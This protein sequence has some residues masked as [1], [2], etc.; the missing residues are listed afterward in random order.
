MEGHLW[1]TAMG[2]VTLDN[3]NGEKFTEPFDRILLTK[4]ELNSGIN[5]GVFRKR[6]QK[7]RKQ[8]LRR[9]NKVLEL[10]KMKE[11]RD[12]LDKTIKSLENNAIS[13]DNKSAEGE[14]NG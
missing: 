8:M 6:Y 12:V 1:L 9:E 14:K 11:Q 7:I 13:E 10:D 4:E 5:Y 3:H 2:R